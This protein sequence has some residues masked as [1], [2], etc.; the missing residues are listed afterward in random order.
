M[1]ISEICFEIKGA[2]GPNITQV[3]K[4]VSKYKKQASSA[5]QLPLRRETIKRLIGV[6]FCAG[7]RLFT[8]DP[9]RELPDTW[10]AW[11]RNVLGA[12][13]L[14]AD[15]IEYED[16][17]A[18]AYR[19]AYI[20]EAG[21]RLVCTLQTARTCPIAVSCATSSDSKSWRRFTGWRF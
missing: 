18:R 3:V 21:W 1:G 13:D 15:Y 14:G 6:S 11:G 9:G 8:L 7:I 2:R 20:V 12:T 5:F 16:A 4:P 17:A 10:T 19:A